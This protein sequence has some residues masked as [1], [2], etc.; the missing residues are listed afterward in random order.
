MQTEHMTRYVDPDRIRLLEWNLDA[1]RYLLRAKIDQLPHR[2]YLGDPTQQTPLTAWL[3]IDR[4]WN[5]KR[6]V[7]ENLESYLLRHTRL[8]PR[9]II[10]LL[11]LLHA[12]AS[13]AKAESRDLSQERLRQVVAEAARLFGT[14]QLAIAGNQLAIGDMPVEAADDDYV[15]T[16]TGQHPEGVRGES[17]DAPGIQFDPSVGR[18]MYRGLDVYSGDNPVLQAAAA[19]QGG[20]IDHLSA[21]IRSIGVDRFGPKKFAQAMKTADELFPGGRALSVLWQNGLLGYTDGPLATGAPVF[22]SATHTDP[23]DIATDRRGYVLHP[24][25]IDALGI[26]SHGAPIYPFGDRA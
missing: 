3:G 20:M 8:I 5:E 1:I 2:F 19:Y 16:Y 9:D 22:Y 10:I 26:K 21:L 24:C 15:E 6:K 25:L 12:Q 13:G 23:L 14:E 7:A 4:V 11:N 17:K 18:Y